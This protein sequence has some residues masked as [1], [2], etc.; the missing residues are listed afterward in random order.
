MK[1]QK[2][3]SQNIQWFKYI[4]FIG[5]IFGLYSLFKISD[6]EEIFVA[7]VFISIG[8]VISY[9]LHNTRILKYD[10]TYLHINLR[11]NINKIPLKNIYK[12]E[13]SM[14][15]IHHTS[16]VV[17]QYKDENKVKKTNAL[18]MCI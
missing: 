9:S 2:R 14:I 4:L 8:F 18:T 1:Q 15:K 17:I 3:L 6:T 10:N 5:A 11:G 12:M 16:V 7:L 13:M